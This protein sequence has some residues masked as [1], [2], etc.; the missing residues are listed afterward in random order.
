MSTKERRLTIARDRRLAV[1]IAEAADCAGGVSKGF[2]RLEIARGRLR[3][4]KVGGRV[5]IPMSALRQWLG[6][7]A[8]PR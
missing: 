8:D 1:G 2:V 6:L 5:L 3:A 7:D 4:R